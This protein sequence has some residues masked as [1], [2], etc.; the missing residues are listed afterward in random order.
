MTRMDRNNK[1][2]MI[3]RN[4]MENWSKKLFFGI[5]AIVSGKR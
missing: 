5:A 3:E 2:F 4:G 1:N